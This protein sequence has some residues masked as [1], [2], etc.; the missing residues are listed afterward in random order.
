MDARALVGR[1]ADLLTAAPIQ[2][3]DAPRL[4][5]A[6]QPKAGTTQLHRRM[7]A[8]SGLPSASLVPDYGGR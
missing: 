3:P 4:L 1:L 6:G 7:C 2:M 5:I 8:L